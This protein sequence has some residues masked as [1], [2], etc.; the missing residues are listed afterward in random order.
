LNF[1]F[2]VFSPHSIEEGLDKLINWK[3]I[4]TN[5][6]TYGGFSTFVVFVIVFIILICY[7]KSLAL[8]HS[9]VRYK[10]V[11]YPKEMRPLRT[12]NDE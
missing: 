7:C 4:A 1:A 11:A 12:L 6:Y 8:D 3:K 2:L 5:P 10:N 9:F